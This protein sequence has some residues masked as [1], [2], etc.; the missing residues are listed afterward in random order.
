MTETVINT[1][2]SDGHSSVRLAR[3]LSLP[4]AVLFGLGV[5]IGAGIYVLIGAAAGRAGLQAPIAFVLAAIVMAPTAATF[6][7]F[8]GRLPVSAGE[9][10]YV[11]EG[12]R[13]ERLALVVGVLVIC[14]AILSAAAISRGSA[15][16]VSALTL[17][18][19][20]VSIILV[21]LGM[22]AVT[23]WG[24]RESALIAGLMTLIEIGGLM[25]I[26]I[27]GAWNSPDILGKVPEIWAGALSVPGMTGILAATMLAF[28][29]FIGFESLANIAEEVK[30]PEH[31]LPRAI[32]LTL[33]LSTLLYIAV[34]WVALL[35]VPKDDLARSAAPLSLVFERVTGASPA[36]ITCIAIIATVNG[37]IIQ[38]IM[39]SR[40][41]YG[42][43]DRHLLP[44]ALARIHPVTKT[45]LYATALTV[46]ITLI[47][48]SL[49][50]LDRLA[51]LTSRVTLV[52][53]AL[54]NAALVLIKLRDDSTQSHGWR[55]ATWVPVVGCLLC[56]ALLIADL[57]VVPLAD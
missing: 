39:A 4:L 1:G 14:V 22:G 34:V 36:V 51:E 53:L 48:A 26:V 35:S 57:V 38:M 10:A 5:T 20:D 21:V 16:Y 52:I 2:H 43:A 18:P 7:E 23:A 3:S 25:A 24:I 33:A 12:F 55:V 46:L 13:S 28:F 56:I 41:L 9:A 32:F 8:A 50:P 17:I 54:V 40:V 30:Q 11:R 15:G 29:A 37:V 45:P 42:L 31:T 47:L 44:A 27:V 6:A 19:I 49:I